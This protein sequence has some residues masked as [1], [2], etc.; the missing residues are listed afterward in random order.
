M[1][2]VAKALSTGTPVRATSFTLRVTRVR[3]WTRA[4]AAISPLPAGSGSGTF[5]RPQSAATRASTSSALP[6]VPH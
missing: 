4:V 2:Y 6:A 3:P 1:T 5:K